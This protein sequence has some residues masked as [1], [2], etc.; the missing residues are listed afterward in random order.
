[1]EPAHEVDFEFVNEIKGGS[2][3]TEF[4]PACEAGFK[5]A[6]EKG[7]L[8]GFPVIRTRVVINDGT[9]HSV[10]S[11]EMAFNT[12][13][14]GAFRSVYNKA[15]PYILEPIM[16]V[17][18]ETPSEFA[19]NVFASITQRRGV[20]IAS[21]EDGSF[22]RIEAE[23]PLS[24]MFGYSTSLRSMTQGKAE[25]SMEFLKYGKVPKS[26]SEELIAEYQ[27]KRKKEQGK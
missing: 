4:I 25:F 16:Q 18:V 21:I 15:K 27:E 19:G 10:D 22:S 14:I 2:I 17:S 5:T 3:P 12:A 13:A 1:V 20:I 24:E 23:V 8:I 11:S 7:S 9:S 26:I 6:T